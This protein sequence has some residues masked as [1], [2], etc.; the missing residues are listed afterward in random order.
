ME[1]ERK[2]KGLTSEE[3]L[4]RRKEY[5]ENRLPEEKPVSVHEIVINQLKSPLIYIIL[6]AAGVSLALGETGDFWIIMVVVLADV[7]LGF[8]QEYK[9][10]RTYVALKGLLHPTTTVCRDG[11]RTE[12]EVWEL[13]PGDLVILCAGEKVPADGMLV[14]AAKMTVDE[15]ILT[16][17]CEPVTRLTAQ[18]VFMGTTTV[19]GRG[20]LESG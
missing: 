6:A 5:G 13:V 7:V 9:A 14:E 10:Q 11:E 1:S 15:S 8:F 17:E 18:Q 16:G 2:L 4:T 3:V 19:T 20:I 12:V